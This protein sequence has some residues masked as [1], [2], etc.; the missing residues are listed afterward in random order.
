MGRIHTQPPIF[1]RVE[2]TYRCVL[3]FDTTD[4]V[5]AEDRRGF[6]VAYIKALKELTRWADEQS[7]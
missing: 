7:R 5:E 3:P 4:S 6:D 2:G 1:Q